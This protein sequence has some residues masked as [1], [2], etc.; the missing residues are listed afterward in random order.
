MSEPDGPMGGK[1][2][3]E[4]QMVIRKDTVP[5]ELATARGEIVRG[6]IFVR[7]HEGA[8]RGERLLDVLSQRWFVPVKTPEKLVFVAVRH[9]AW[10]KL[11]LLAAIDELDPDAENDDTS[12]RAHVICECIDGTRIDGNVRYA[13]PAPARR[14]GDYLEHLPN[15]FPISTEDFVFLVNS[16]CVV[17]VTPLE[18]RR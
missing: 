10:V 12:C 2:P 8:D 5:V 16:A 17:S 18:E 6:E 15:F 3:S 1:D 4:E 11:E 13:L 9:L 7:P 14:V